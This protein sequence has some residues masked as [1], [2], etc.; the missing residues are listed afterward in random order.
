MYM[1]KILYFYYLYRLFE[2]NLN[3]LHSLHSVVALP[4]SLLYLVTVSRLT[5]D[6]LFGLLFAMHIHG[7]SVR[8]LSDI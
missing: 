1:V 6:C 7:V 4:F 8:Y 3:L 5:S 2:P